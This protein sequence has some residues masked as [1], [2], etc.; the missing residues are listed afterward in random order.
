MWTSDF[1]CYIE[2]IVAKDQAIVKEHFEFQRSEK[3]KENVQSELNRK[4][5]MIQSNHD[6]IH[7]QENELRN[8]SSTLRRMDEEALAQRKVTEMIC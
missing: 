2:E 4:N 6:L 7:Q 3:L 1:S 5:Q 8:L